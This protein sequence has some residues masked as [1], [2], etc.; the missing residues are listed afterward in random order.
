MGEFSALARSIDG[1]RSIEL[2]ANMNP[3]NLAKSLSHGVLVSFEAVPA[4]YHYL[5]HLDNRALKQA[6]VPLL[7]D[8]LC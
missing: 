6:L 8:L 5:I 1:I 2:E 4:Q 7:A 3:E